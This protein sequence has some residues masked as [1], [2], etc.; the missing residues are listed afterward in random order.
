MVELEMIK[1][2]KD[3]VTTIETVGNVVFWVVVS[4]FAAWVIGKFIV[5]IG[6]L[7]GEE[8]EDVSP[9]LAKEEV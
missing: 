5:N 2:S 4:M 1:L 9:V 3:L 6:K 7:R 8:D